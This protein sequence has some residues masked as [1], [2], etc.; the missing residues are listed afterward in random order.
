MAQL[1]CQ[2]LCVGY[3]DDYPEL[4]AEITVIGEFQSYEEN[5]II[6]YHLISA[7]MV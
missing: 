1:T 2:N 4:G 7:R 3:P 5:G 6:W